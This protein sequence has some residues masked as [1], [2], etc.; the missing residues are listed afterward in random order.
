MNI[1]QQIRHQRILPSNKHELSVSEVVA[2]A[3]SVVN[4]CEHVGPM[5][6]DQGIGVYRWR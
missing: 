6:H 3:T 2:V 1:K 4:P 5:E